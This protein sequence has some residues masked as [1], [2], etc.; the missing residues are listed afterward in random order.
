MAV[1]E[2]REVGDEGAEVVGALDQDEA[3]L[4]TPRAGPLRDQ[5]VECRMA[6]GAVAGDD[7]GRVAEMGVV[8]DRSG[9]SPQRRVRGEGHGAAVGR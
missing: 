6:E 5:P 2:R 3:A 4:G 1:L 8:E 9:R 7:G